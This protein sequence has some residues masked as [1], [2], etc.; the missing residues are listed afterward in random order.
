MNLSNAH[1]VWSLLKLTTLTFFHAFV[2]IKCVVFVGT[3]L[4]Q[5]KMGYV[6]HVER[7]V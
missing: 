6:L 2:V 7:L 1:Y 5:M 3:E 4:E